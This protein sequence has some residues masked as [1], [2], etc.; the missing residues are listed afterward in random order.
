[1]KQIN[2]NYS[3]IFYKGIYCFIDD[4]ASDT[5]SE[6]EGILGIDISDKL[7]LKSNVVR[8]SLKVISDF[9]DDALKVLS[10]KVDWAI[11]EENPTVINHELSMLYEFNLLYRR[12]ECLFNVLRFIRLTGLSKLKIVLCETR[13]ISARSDSYFKCI[14]GHYR[15]KYR[16]ITRASDMNFINASSV[17]GGEA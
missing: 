1:M 6:Y 17:C 5:K 4:L 2:D 8:S 11:E 12:L 3:E 9:I 15:G 13:K 10:R 14:L 7:N 16:R